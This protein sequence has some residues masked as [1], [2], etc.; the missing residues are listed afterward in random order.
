MKTHEQTVTNNNSHRQISR[1]RAR[2]G[3]LDG[4]GKSKREGYRQR[5]YPMID[6]SPRA[7]LSLLL[8]AM[9]MCTNSLTNCSTPASTPSPTTTP[10]AP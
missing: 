6:H 1:G 2:E 3:V 10:I 8:R 9:K 4:D 7:K 5:D